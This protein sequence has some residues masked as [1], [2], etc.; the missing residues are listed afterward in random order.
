MILMPIPTQTLTELA[1]SF[2]DVIPAVDKKAQHDRW[3]AGIGPFEEEAQLAMI[4]EALSDA[5]RQPWPIKQE[6]QYPESPK[7]CDLVVDADGGRLP[8][9]VKLLRFRRDNGNIDPN[10]YKSV[11]SP[12]PE[13]SSSSMLTDAKKLVD[14]EF[15]QPTGLVGLYYERDEEPYEQLTA[16]MIAEKFTQDVGFWYDIDIKTVAIE[17]FGGLQHPHHQRGAVIAWVL[18]E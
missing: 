3:K 2:A 14:S 9:E 13:R 5:D 16:D 10:M 6:V 11:F 1:Q 18:E 8:T 4:L 15:T 12:F 7:R 17:S